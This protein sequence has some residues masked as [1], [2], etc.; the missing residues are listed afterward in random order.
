L[1]QKLAEQ[2][3]I[4]AVRSAEQIQYEKETEKSKKESQALAEKVKQR[5]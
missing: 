5:E 3:K 1:Y 4:I 2:N